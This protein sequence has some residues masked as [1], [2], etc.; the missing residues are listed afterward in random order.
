MRSKPSAST[1]LAS[2]PRMRLLALYRAV[3]PVEQ[4][5]FTFEMGMP[6]I[7]SWYSALCKH[8][9]SNAMSVGIKSADLPGCGVSVAV[10]YEGRLNFI[11]GDILFDIRIR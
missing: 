8:D 7:P 10:A 5:L 9:R 6:V 3:L 2:P 11:I 4:L 1:Q